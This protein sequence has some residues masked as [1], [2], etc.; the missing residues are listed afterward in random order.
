MV[1]GRAFGDTLIVVGSPRSTATTNQ[2][3][4]DPGIGRGW[5]GEP[6]VRHRRGARVL[7]GS[8]GCERAK[9]TTSCCGRLPCEF[10]GSEQEGLTDDP[11]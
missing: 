1:W 4:R 5:L 6:R 9:H 11:R 2:R 8:A 3:R 7:T 10:Q